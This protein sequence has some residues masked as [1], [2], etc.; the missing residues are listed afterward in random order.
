M[1]TFEGKR[2]LL[3]GGAGFIGSWIAQKLCQE[4]A[5]VRVYDNFSSG[6]KD[7]LKHLDVEIIEG[8]I[9]DKKGLKEAMMDCDL[10]SHQ[11]AQL[12]ITHCIKNPEKD[13]QV[14]A[15]GT[16]CVLQVA[17][18]VDSIQKVIMASSACVY[19]QTNHK[20][21]EESHPTNPNW[22]Y[23]VS[24][25]A[26]EKYCHIFSQTTKIPTVCLRYAIVYGP[27]EWYG[28][29]LTIF[30]KR[31]LSGLQ[32]VIFSDGFVKRDFVFVE[33]VARFHN[34]SIS[35]DT[36]LHKVFNVGT[37]VATSIRDLAYLVIDI[38]GLKNIPVFEGI[39]EGECSELVEEN[40]MRLPQELKQII[41][42]PTMGNK[43][44]GFCPKT[45]L[46]EGLLLELAWLQQNRDRWEKMS[47]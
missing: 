37:G 19:G 38:F 24:K 36:G 23:G 42:S 16:L 13:L 43:I 4:G 32:P 47:Y 11:A 25:L 34:L 22:A 30:L 20:Q 44:L 46:S 12:E 27:R 29:V 7:N 18:E 9:L 8:D 26:A 21:S 45:S 41:L 40:R 3:T 1:I 28:R 33:D 17:Q 10:V 35:K 2:I 6:T 39:A 14:N 15:I 31:A 5:F